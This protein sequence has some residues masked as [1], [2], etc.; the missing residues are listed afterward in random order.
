[1]NTLHTD[2]KQHKA[3]FNQLVS[4]KSEHAVSGE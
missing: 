1:M 2:T 4:G 3:V